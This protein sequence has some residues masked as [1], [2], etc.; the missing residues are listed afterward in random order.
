MVREGRAIC[1]R[2][3]MIS[4]RLRSP[5]EP[6][7]QER[8]A[9]GGLITRPDAPV[10]KREDA[11]PLDTLFYRQLAIRTYTEVKVTSTHTHSEEFSARLRQVSLSL[12]RS[13]VCFNVS[14][15]LMEST[16]ARR[17]G[18]LFR[19]KA[20]TTP[21]IRI[22]L[23][24]DRNRALHHRRPPQ[25]T[26]PTKS[27]LLTLLIGCCLLLLLQPSLTH[28]LLLLLARSCSRLVSPILSLC[29]YVSGVSIT[30]GV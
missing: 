1:K 20:G 13:R 3:L 17:T 29:S 10:N 11:T 22:Q 21:Y 14:E 9:G 4:R 15:I 8:L 19:R 27:R 12:Q 16:L 6:L 5:G 18:H 30:L 26:Y 7:S 25:I 23:L 24:T 28:L 2:A